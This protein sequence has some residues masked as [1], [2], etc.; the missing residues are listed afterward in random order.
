MKLSADTLAHLRG[1]RFAAG[2]DV[3]FEWEPEDWTYRSR[4]A[5]LADM[6]RGKRIIHL[7][8]VDHDAHEVQ[9]KMARG[10]WLHKILTDSAATC[11]GV[12][13]SRPGIEYLHSIGVTNTMVADITDPPAELRDARWDC[14]MIPEVLEHIGNPVSFLAGIHRAF[15]GNTGSVV[16]TVPNAFAQE[17]VDLARRHREVINSDHRHWY[18]PFTLAKVA[19]DAG[20]VVDRM[21]LCKVGVVNRYSFFRNWRFARQPLL[22]NGLI[23]EARF[24]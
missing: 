12:D 19:I 16:I 15:A 8:C 10:K 6:A 24:R 2:L 4:L 22:R 3:G 14:L 11:L 17:N 18:T 5:L 20:F 1:D 9:H 7:G 13:I 23:L 21:H